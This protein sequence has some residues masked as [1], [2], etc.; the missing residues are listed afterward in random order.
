MNAPTK[1]IG[2]P[3]ITSNPGISS[4]APIIEGTRIT[5][6]CLAGYY[7]MGMTVDDILQSLPHLTAAQVHAGLAYYFDH[8]EEIDRDLAENQDIDLWQSRVMPHPKV[9]ASRG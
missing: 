7:Q 1:Q 2:Y 5:V 8:Q 6:R 4:G 9:S 3:H